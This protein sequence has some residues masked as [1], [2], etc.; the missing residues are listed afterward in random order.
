MWQKNV[1]STCQNNRSGSNKNQ[2]K[3]NMTNKLHMNVI[4]N[5]V[6]EV[7]PF[8]TVVS[9]IKFYTFSRESLKLI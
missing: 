4:V 5:S 6:S 2:R 8:E 7:I 1:T 9:A 3:E